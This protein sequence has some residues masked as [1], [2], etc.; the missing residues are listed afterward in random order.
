MS[1][2][3]DSRGW[4]PS[5][6]IRHK[7]AV[8]VKSLTLAQVLKVFQQWLYLPDPGVVALTLAAVTANRMAGD[9][10]WL[11]LI[12]APSSGK[13]EILDSLLD[14]PHMH[15]AATLTDAS[16]LSGVPKRE[17]STTSTGGLLRV[18]GDFGFLVLKDFYTRDITL[19]PGTERPARLVLALARLLHGMRVIGAENQEAWRLLTNVVLDCIPAVRKAALQQMWRGERQSTT[20]IATAI[21][22][23]TTTTRRALEDLT[24]HG[25]LTRYSMGSGKPDEWD[26]S[27]FGKGL[28]DAIE[29]VPE[30]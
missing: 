29:S 7:H 1:T 12:G 18:I 11:L 20:A 17:H 19:V 9:P 14:L 26:L 23:P 2:Q 22:Y 3:K 5:E 30:K 24:A 6:R 27:L 16:L 8:P 4:L 21:D 10:V 15:P 28:R 13:T 25:L